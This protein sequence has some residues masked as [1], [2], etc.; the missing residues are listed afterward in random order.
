MK[1][2]DIK[3][4]DLFA[5]I[6]GTRIA[7]ERAGARCVFSSEWDKHS[8][9]TY[10][11]FFGEMPHGDIAD[12]AIK[13]AIPGFNI[14]VAGFPC[15]PFSSIGKRQGFSHT[16]QGTLFHHI[17]EILK[18]K[19][20]D[21]LL[22]EN[23]KGLRTHDGGNTYRVVVASL[24][25][26]GY[27]INDTLLNASAYGV[28]QKRERTYIVGFRKTLVPAMTE[29]DA[30]QKIGFSFSNLKKNG[31]V[32]L[33]EHIE[34]GVNDRPITKHLQKVYINKLNDGRPQILVPGAKGQISNTLVSSYHKIQRLTGIF[35]SDGPTGLRLLSEN[36]CRAI[37]G[38]PK[39]GDIHNGRVLGP[40]PV[41]RSQM[42]RQF[43]NSVAVPVVELIAKRMVKCLHPIIS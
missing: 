41:S 42:Y 4:I 30:F 17:V 8:Q 20:P 23:V 18:K 33:D 14:L 2:K 19:K 39:V 27:W 37:M 24:R 3:F 31:P 25:D 21:A 22:L 26:A 43:G 6:G 32:Y 16:T 38:F 13:K 35:V 36:E 12:P 9:A 40:V 28:P 34:T 1:K 10:N 11:A 29:Q 15:Q 5:G 7:F